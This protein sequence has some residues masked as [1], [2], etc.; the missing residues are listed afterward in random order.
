V[1]DVFGYANSSEKAGMNAYANPK[2]SGKLAE[3]LFFL[4]RKIIVY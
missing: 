1:S 3:A 2:V 4:K